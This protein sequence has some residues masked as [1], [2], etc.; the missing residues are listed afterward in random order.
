M[1][2]SSK[3]MLWMPESIK[4]WFLMCFSSMGMVPNH[5]LD[6]YIRY[7]GQNMSQNDIEMI[8]K[9]QN[10]FKNWFWEAPGGSGQ[11][12]PAA[13]ETSQESR[14]SAWRGEKEGGAPRKNHL[15]ADPWR[16][17]GFGIYA[18]NGAGFLVQNWKRYPESMFY[19]R[20]TFPLE[21][22]PQCQC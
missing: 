17:G 7:D 18:K 22:W 10:C 20:N 11:V 12:R 9:I 16:V 4:K 1:K 13:P 3:S 19:S 2:N 5:I 21:L 6:G 15:N 14:G 8:K